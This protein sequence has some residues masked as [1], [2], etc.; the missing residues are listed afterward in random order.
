MCKGWGNETL[1]ICLILVVIIALLYYDLPHTEFNPA[2]FKD[3][4]TFNLKLIISGRRGDVV[5]YNNPQ[6]LIIV[7][8]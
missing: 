6:V 8:L 5:A 4:S 2:N 7:S 3:F 1:K